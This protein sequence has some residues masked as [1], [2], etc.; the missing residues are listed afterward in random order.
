[1]A[2]WRFFL[3]DI[4]VEEPIG[5]DAV[6][7]TALRTDSD[8]IDQPF[9]TE[10]S[11][12]GKGAKLIK[13]LY[14]VY[15]INAEITIKITS[16]VYINGVA[17]EFNGF[18]NLSV[19]SE[20]NVC[21]TDSWQITVGIIDDNFREKFKSRMGV[22][23][24]LNILKDLDGNV[25]A[26]PTI[27]T[28]RLHTQE[29]YLT[30][31]AND[32]IEENTNIPQYAT[33]FWTYSGGWV[34]EDFAAII[35][36]YFQ[37][38]DFA[39]PFGKTFDL[40]QIKWHPTKG[41]CFKNNTTFTRT[42][43]FNVRINGQFFWD[44]VAVAGE[45]AN[46]VISL[47]VTNGD[48]GNGSSQTQRYYGPSSANCIVAAPIIPID[49]DF[50]WEQ[51]VTLAP[52]NRVL[53]FLQWANGGSVYP[54]WEPPDANPRS[55][56]LF[57]DDCCL[58]ITEKNSAAYS[59]FAETMRAENFLRRLVHIITGDPNGLVS[60]TFS[61]NGDGCYWDYALT[62]GL[63]IRQAKTLGQLEN[64][65][66][67]LSD[68]TQNSFKISFDKIFEGLNY[69]FCLGWDFVYINGGWK[70]RI[71]TLEFFYQNQINFTAINVGE[72][73][74]SAM[75]SELANQIVIGY[76]DKWKNIQVS[77]IWAI[78]TDRNYYINNRAMS[79]GTSKKLELLSPIIAEGYAIE[80][81]RRL[82]QIQDNSG[83]SDRPNDYNLFIIWLNRNEL[84]ITN[85][86]NSEYKQRTETGT[87]VFAAGEVS[88]SSS[89]IN[90]SNSEVHALYNI[91]ITPTRNAL[92]WWKK[93]G[94]HTYG[95]VN[96]RMR[97]QV[98][99]YQTSYSSFID[100][101]LEPC[102]EACDSCL[103]P[104][105]TDIYPSLFRPTKSE[106]LFK[107]IEIEF[108]YPQSLCDFIDLSDN[109]SYGK[110]KLIS[111]SL[112]VSG[113]ILDMTNKPED[114]NGGTTT[115]KLIA[116]N[117]ADPE[118]PPEGGAYSEAYSSAYS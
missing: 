52:E 103:I 117:I 45:T 109:K 99:Q 76:E 68:T 75:T 116:S 91:F 50:V 97:F 84:T 93:L 111:G 65:C 23:V 36:A 29:L 1:M 30:A 101:T 108:S 37:N 51:T 90:T 48:G 70:V 79:E 18:L 88:M 112:S 59:T 63:K 105:N 106:Y 69:I 82:E 55:L 33:L 39:E 7:F 4:E 67:P 32:L 87:V 113:Y 31:F 57:V 22:E 13:A 100:D 95:L 118:P 80:V 85:I 47:M 14:D 83:S 42:L 104:E 73:T 41:V 98:G 64:P 89:R 9:S 20:F 25:I 28:I 35:P 12:Y 54:G 24:D 96:P 56:A 92:R 26:A 78:H 34:L 115:F 58:T 81:S 66:D 21:D 74:Q 49:Y 94:M 114:A 8:G 5:W 38:S 71:E 43:T 17:W 102:Q 61:K 19:Y 3:N 62:T 53:I 40:Q 46:I 11:F 10:I 44:E 16:D 27:D 107:P 86:Q 6:E 15:F 2:S 77:G 60:E 110:V 72:V